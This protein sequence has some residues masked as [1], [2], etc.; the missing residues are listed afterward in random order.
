MFIL[1]TS[2][3]RTEM[4]FSPIGSS[5]ATPLH[6]A[7]TLR[8]RIFPTRRSNSAAG[9][10][11]PRGLASQLRWWDFL[12]SKIN[13]SLTRLQ[14]FLPLGGSTRR[15]KLA[16]IVVGQIHSGTTSRVSSKHLRVKANSSSKHPISTKS[17]DK[18]NQT[19][20]KQ[21]FHFKNYY[22]YCNF[23]NYIHLNTNLIT[24]N[25][26]NTRSITCLCLLFE[27]KCRQPVPA[28]PD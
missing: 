8:C 28:R 11:P 24:S 21:P 3:V 12:H 17:N 19:R 10:F 25:K 20:S 27:R 23:S 18:T 22:F 1:T 13:A 15:Q 6:P 16:G 14:R 7:K 26:R 5:D 9:I 2:N 4:G